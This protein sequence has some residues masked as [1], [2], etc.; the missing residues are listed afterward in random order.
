MFNIPFNYR[1]GY[2][3]GDPIP[4]FGTAK[5]IVWVDSLKGVYN[6]LPY[7]S[8]T[9]NNNDIRLWQDQTIYGN[10]F[11]AT[12]TNSP[13]YSA[14]TFS[15]YGTSASFPYVE[16]S[17][18]K[19]EYMAAANSPSLQ[20]ISTGFTVFFVFRKNPL[21]TWS[22][23]NPIIEYNAAW[24]SESEGFG[25]DADAGPNFL[26][27]WYYNQ[28][29]NPLTVDVPWGTVINDEKFYYYTFRMS[30]GTVSGYYGSTLYAQATSVGSNKKMMPVSSSAK[31]YIAGGF[32]GTTYAQASAIDVAE[33]LIYDGAVPNSGLVTV[34]NYFKTKYGFT[35]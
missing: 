2:S 23:G 28:S 34:W 3:S 27:F 21:R 30:G 5:A 7:S 4:V 35:T 8:A 18:V 24:A 16:F 29:F 33:V 17:D 12:T 10:N 13:S 1:E 11:T 31:L 15:P 14:T 19:S 25:I 26:N 9:I 32:N 22:S 6:G 20:A